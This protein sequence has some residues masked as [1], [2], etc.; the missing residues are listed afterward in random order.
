MDIVCSKSEGIL[1]LEFNRL[2]RKNAITGA[3]Y[4]TLA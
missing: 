1:T 3:M 4:Q 2:E